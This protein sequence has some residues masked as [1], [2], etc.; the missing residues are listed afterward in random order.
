VLVLV[1]LGLPRTR[2]TSGVRLVLAQLEPELIVVVVQVPVPTES[3]EVS[4]EMMMFSQ[5][6]G[7]S[8]SYLNVFATKLQVIYFTMSVFCEG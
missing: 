8:K 4:G 5:T 1:V 6:C 3:R 7:N 2:R